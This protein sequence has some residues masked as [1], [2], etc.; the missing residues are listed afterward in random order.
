[1]WLANRDPDIRRALEEVAF[2]RAAAERQDLA[3]R[4]ITTLFEIIRQAWKENVGGQL[5]AMEMLRAA[6]NDQRDLRGE[7]PGD[8]LR[9]QKR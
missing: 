9:D 7:F 2:R 4:E 8:R 3:L 1:M 5:V 6:L